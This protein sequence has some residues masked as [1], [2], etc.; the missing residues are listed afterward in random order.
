ML[1]IRHYKGKKQFF[2]EVVMTVYTDLKGVDRTTNEEHIIN[3]TKEKSVAAVLENCAVSLTGKHST[4]FNFSSPLFSA[5][6][7]N[8]SQ[9]NYSFFHQ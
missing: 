6:C 3:T 5:A 2:R 7:V 4:V 9:L 8:N 1:Q